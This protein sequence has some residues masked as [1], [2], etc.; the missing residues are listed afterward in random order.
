M[1][2]IEISRDIVS[3]ADTLD[4]SFTR[5]WDKIECPPEKP[6]AIETLERV[7]KLKTGKRE[8][9]KKLYCPITI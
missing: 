2:A 1:D 4:F 6:D 8:S 7:K 3:I 9:V 5:L